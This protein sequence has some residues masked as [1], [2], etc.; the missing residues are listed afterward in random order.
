MDG[1]TRLILSLAVLLKTNLLVHV[2]SMDGSPSLN[3]RPRE[4]SEELLPAFLNAG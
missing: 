1:L 4:K 2:Q 3:K